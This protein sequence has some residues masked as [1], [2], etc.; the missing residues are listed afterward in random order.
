MYKKKFIATKSAAILFCRGGRGHFECKC[1][2][3]Y[4]SF[5]RN[6]NG[7]VFAATGMTGPSAGVAGGQNRVQAQARHQ[8]GQQR[9]PIQKQIYILYK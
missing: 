5:P 1:V 4:L 2:H 9:Q 6:L 3:M 8:Y 7:H